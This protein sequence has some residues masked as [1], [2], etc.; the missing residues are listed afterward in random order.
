MKLKERLVAA[1][2]GFLAAL[3]LL[4]IVPQSRDLLVRPEAN[5]HHGVIQPAS[6]GSLLRQQ[7]NLQKTDSASEQDQQIEEWQSVPASDRNKLTKK[8]K[9][10]VDV[11]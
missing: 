5:V 10:I 8:V 11:S 1:S 4:L 2:L 3:C 6:P 9:F 7:R